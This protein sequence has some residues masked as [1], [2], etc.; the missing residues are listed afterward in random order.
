M[1][2]ILVNVKKL[3]KEMV[4]TVQTFAKSTLVV[5]E[6]MHIAEKKKKQKSSIVCVMTDSLEM[7]NIVKM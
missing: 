6:S 7:E 3:M 1:V 5:V 2:A 4:M